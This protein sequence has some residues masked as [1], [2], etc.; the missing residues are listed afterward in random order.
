MAKSL[1]ACVF[2]LV[3]FLVGARGAYAQ[4][5]T[6]STVASTTSTSA[7]DCG[8]TGSLTLDQTELCLIQHDTEAGRAENLMAGC[9]LVFLA[10][11]AV[12]LRLW[13]G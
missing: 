6:T 12:M 9:L 10:G 5:T 1:G 4:T 8:A 13:I 11:F 7:P 2:V 3:M